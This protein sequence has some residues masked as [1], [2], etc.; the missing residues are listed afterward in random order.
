M[1]GIYVGACVI[2]SALA[3]RNPRRAEDTYDK[4]VKTVV[5]FLFICYPAISLELF[6]LYQTR[7]YGHVT[8]LVADWSLG[9]EDTSAPISLLGYQM[10]AV[11]FLCLWVVGIPVF[12]F[13]ELWKTARPHAKPKLNLQELKALDKLQVW[14]LRPHVTPSRH[15]ASHPIASPRILS[16]CALRRP[17]L[18]SHRI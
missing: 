11:P 7:R 18:T 14:Q 4:G 17:P 9:Y 10:I 2:S 12:F 8:L 16:R 6:K 1:I 15:I 5:L 3:H 13:A